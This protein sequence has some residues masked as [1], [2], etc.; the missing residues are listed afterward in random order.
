MAVVSTSPHCAVFCSGHQEDAHFNNRS[1]LAKYL[2]I[3]PGAC[4]SKKTC[5]SFGSLGKH[6]SNCKSIKHTYYLNFIIYDV[7][8]ELVCDNF[9][10]M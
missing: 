5:Q 6:T 8:I 4:L 9:C 10:N 2:H 7:S 1:H 3:I